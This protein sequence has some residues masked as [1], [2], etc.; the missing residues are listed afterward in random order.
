[1]KEISK[2]I[3][4]EVGEYYLLKY[5]TKATPWLKRDRVV[6]VKTLDT[7]IQIDTIQGAGF[8]S[9]WDWATKDAVKIIKLRKN[10]ILKNEL[11]RS[12]ELG[13]TIARAELPVGHPFR[14]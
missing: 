3:N 10:N 2:T 6:F 5:D 14:P 4:P 13:R 9:R 12:I 1:M 7:F 11:N 8:S